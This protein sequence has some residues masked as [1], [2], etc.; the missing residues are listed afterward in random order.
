[1]SNRSRRKDA[2]GELAITK[3][4]QERGLIAPKVSAMYR[5]GE[6]ISVSLLG[7]DRK[8]EVKIRGG[9]FAQLYRWLGQNFALVIRRDRDVP[10]IVLRLEDAAAIAAPAERPK[11]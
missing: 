6:D 9:G 5:P 8:L 7:L 3:L 11:P 2:R 10:L 1:M 4:L